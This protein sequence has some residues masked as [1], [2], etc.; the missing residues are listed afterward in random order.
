MTSRVLGLVRDQ[1]LAYLFGAGNEVDAYNVAFRVPNLIR[2]LFAEGAMSAAFV[3]TFTREL[4]RHGRHAAWRLSNNVITALVLVTAM[5]VVAGIVW[6]GPLISTYAGEYASVPGKLE[7][8]I[9]LTRLMLPFLIL[10]AVAAAFMGM[11]NS[12]DRFFV[13]ALSPALFNVGSILC[14]VTLAP[15]MPRFGLQPIVAM[16]IGVLVGGLG[17]LVAQWPALRREGYH[18]RP[19]LDLRDPG[20]QQ[21]LL[22]MG[23]GT[24]GL[25]ATQINVFV[26]TILATTE[27]T[28]AVSWLNYA[29]RLMYLPLGIF[30]LSIATAAMPAVARFAAADDV[31]GLRHEVANALVM[32]LLLN[33]P[34]TFGLIVL[35]HPIVALLFE[36][37]AFTPA[38]TQATAA[39]L[40]CYA[41]G[42]TGYSVVKIA[43]PTF[44]ALGDSRTPVAVSAVTVLANAALN[45]M[46]VR[47]LGYVGLAIGTSVT[48]LMNAVVLLVL[49]RRRLRGFEG[50]RLASVIAR[51]LVASAVMAVAAYL[52]DAGLLRLWPD[53]TLA[54]QATRV[55]VS[56]TSALIVLVATAR[57]LRLTEL[58]DV[59]QAAWDRLRVM[60]STARARP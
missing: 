21:V 32:M 59:A 49:L 5:I 10:V 40:I 2:D 57:A 24:L 23:P 52:V 29:F 38:D 1:V 26:N 55:L 35:A 54:A 14:V 41:V 19:T 28:G 3:P 58:D 48:A 9:Q 8:T 51:A 15:L 42:L 60:V 36:R 47:Y 16:G 56:I 27:G 25:A 11:L 53:H 33:V 31:D 17:Q 30:G 20:L 6:A 39:A 37:G 34:A 7:L 45:V 12:L 22:L 43:S 4:T 44:Y 46:L 18:Y 50:P 13:P